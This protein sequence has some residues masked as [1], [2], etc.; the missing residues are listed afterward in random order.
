[1][2]RRDLVVAVIGATGVVGEELLALLEERGFPVG[3]LRAFGSEESA[4]AELEFAGAR[5]VVEALDPGRVAGADLV[6]CA[7][8]GVLAPLLEPL[9]Q[10]GARLV[11]LSGGLE[12]DLGV[13]LWLPGGSTGPGRAW[14][15]I[16]RGVVGALGVALLP[17]QRDVGL[18]RVTAVCLE[19]AVGA[20]RRGVEELSDQTLALLGGMTGEAGDSEVFPQPLAFDC[21]P[22]VGLLLEGGDTSEERRLA[23]VLRRLLAAPGL[24][25]ESTRVRVPVFAGSLACVHVATARELAPG[26]AIEL[27]EKDAAIEVLPGDVLPTPRGTGGTDRVRIGRVR[28]AAGPAPGLAFALAQDDLRR[29]SALA[30]VEAAESLLGGL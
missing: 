1:M 17:L 12:L 24:T 30:A 27:W 16:P 19:P 18:E 4:G 22:S 11:D 29:G 5:I 8:S 3:E 13:P 7:A 28:R 23:H 6:F 26:R 15:A 20:G 14:R 9:E 2:A 21:L 25:V 10:S